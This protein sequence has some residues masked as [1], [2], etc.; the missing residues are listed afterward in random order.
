MQALRAVPDSDSDGPPPLMDSESGE[1]DEEMPAEYEYTYQ[2]RPFSAHVM[3]EANG[4]GSRSAPLHRPTTDGPR[5]R[6]PTP[7]PHVYPTTEVPRQRPPRKPKAGRQHG[8]DV[9]AQVR[10]RGA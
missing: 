9:V 5:Q 4:F 2:H 1:S 10:S 8:N 7:V 6:T 3:P